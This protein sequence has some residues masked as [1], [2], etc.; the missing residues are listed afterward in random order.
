MKMAA[1]SPSSSSSSLPSTILWPL[2]LSM[3]ITAKYS[4]SSL[5]S[6]PIISNQ[7]IVTLLSIKYDKTPICFL[8]YQLLVILI[9]T[10]QIITP[11]L[12]IILFQVY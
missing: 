5:P 2:T 8:N 11:T 3:S 9:P 12:F 4:T 7:Y 10:P 1:T 6:T